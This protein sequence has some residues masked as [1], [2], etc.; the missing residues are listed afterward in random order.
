MVDPPPSPDIRIGGLSNYYSNMYKTKNMVKTTRDY[1]QEDVRKVSTL[2]YSL[3]VDNVFEYNAYIYNLVYLVEIND[4]HFD[5][6]L[7]VDSIVSREKF[8]LAFRYKLKN[9]VIFFGN[10]MR[11]NVYNFLP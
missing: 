11:C 10:E 4:F 6:Y 9:Y 7:M 1:V 8:Y 3:I 5:Q 2:N